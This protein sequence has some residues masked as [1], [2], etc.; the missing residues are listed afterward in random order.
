[1]IRFVRHRFRTVNVRGVRLSHHGKGLYDETGGYHLC[2]RRGHASNGGVEV[3]ERGGRR[4]GGKEN[5]FFNTTVHLLQ[6]RRL[7]SNFILSLVS[8]A[9]VAADCR[10]QDHRAIREA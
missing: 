9:V 5:V 3:R 4:G 10:R 2:F 8:G 6:L 1:M 7:W